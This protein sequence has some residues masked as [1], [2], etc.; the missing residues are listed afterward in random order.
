VLGPGQAACTGFLEYTLLWGTGVPREEAEGMLSL[1]T[2]LC[3]LGQRAASHRPHGFLQSLWL[4]FFR[5]FSA[6][7]A[8]KVPL[9]YPSPLVPGGP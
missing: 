9:L 1:P 6:R 4:S 8:V 5:A 2:F 3:Y 7:S